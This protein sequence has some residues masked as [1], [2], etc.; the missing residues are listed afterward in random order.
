MLL[1]IVIGE[2]DGQATLFANDQLNELKEAE[3]SNN[4]EEEAAKLVGHFPFTDKNNIFTDWHILFFGQLQEFVLIR[5]RREPA[6]GHAGDFSFEVEIINVL[7]KKGLLFFDG[8]EVENELL[9]GVD[10][11]LAP[12]LNYNLDLL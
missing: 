5:R 2:I 1:L 7:H 6:C 11:I 3:N 4:C 10:N 8:V 12:D 9:Q